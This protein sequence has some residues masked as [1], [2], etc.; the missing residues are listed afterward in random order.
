[1]ALAATRE[2]DAVRWRA[3]GLTWPEVGAKLAEEQGSPKALDKSVVRKAYKRG[4]AAM[5]EEMR[6]N[7]REIVTLGLVRLDLAIP[8]VME[9]AEAGDDAAILSLCRIIKEQRSLLTMTASDITVPSTREEMVR[10]LDEMLWQRAM[11]GDTA[12]AAR[13]LAA[14]APDRYGKPAA[15]DGDVIDSTATPADA[16]LPQKVVFAVM[17]SAE[18]DAV[19]AEVRA[20]RGEMLPAE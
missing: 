6:A 3:R 5:Q 9:R 16:P 4:L 17:T 10:Q 20:E 2:Y 18:A 7:I 8:K 12:A 1:M 15:D 13:W 11:A 19:R 14:N